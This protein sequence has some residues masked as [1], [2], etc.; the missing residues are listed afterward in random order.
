M[1][2]DHEQTNELARSAGKNTSY[3]A[4][5]LLTAAHV[6][7]DLPEI[8]QCLK[9]CDKFSYAKFTQKAT[10]PLFS[11][12]ASHIAEG[13]LDRPSITKIQSLFHIKVRGDALF[14]H[15]AQST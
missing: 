13:F 8:A 9:V 7:E 2:C 12:I 15:R 4:M 14:L 5:K 10:K 11:F 1:S 6:R 3:F